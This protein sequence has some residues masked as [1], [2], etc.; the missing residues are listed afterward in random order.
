MSGPI[1]SLKRFTG[2]PAEQP[3]L[4]WRLWDACSV[5]YV[6]ITCKEGHAST[7]ARGRKLTG[8]TADSHHIRDDGCVKCMA[9]C[10]TKGCTHHS[11]VFLQDWQNPWKEQLT[12]VSTPASTTDEPSLFGPS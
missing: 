1:V 3:P 7:L 5:L 9:V 4:S 12:P 8:P 10:P 11:L 6:I 2:L